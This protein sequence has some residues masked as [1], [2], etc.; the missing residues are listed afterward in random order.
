MVINI[1]FDRKY[2][3]PQIKFHAWLTRD[4]RETRFFFLLLFF[5][6]E[7]RIYFPLFLARRLADKN[8]LNI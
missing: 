7:M 3:P 6:A 5:L 1:G 4:E 2:V 8:Y